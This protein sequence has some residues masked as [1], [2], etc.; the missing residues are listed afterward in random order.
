[1]TASEKDREIVRR[2]LIRGIALDEEGACTLRRAAL[3][4][5]R[6]D[7]AQCGADGWHIERDC[8]GLPWRV[9]HAASH[10][11]IRYRIP[12][13]EA[14]AWRRAVKVAER[15]GFSITRQPDPRGCPLCIWHPLSGSPDPWGGVGISG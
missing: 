3:V 7:E 4:L 14:H 9:I 11:D 1:M 10:R 5:S 13:A 12:D 6:W 8:N 2:A 15:C